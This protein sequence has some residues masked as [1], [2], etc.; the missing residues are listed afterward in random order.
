MAHLSS[1]PTGKVTPKQF[2]HTLHEQ[3]LLSLRQMLRKPLSEHTVRQWLIK[4]GW[5]CTMLRKGMYMDGYE[6]P[7]VVQYQ[8]NTFLPLMAL[9]EKRMVEWIT[10]GFKLVFINPKLGPDE[11]RVIVVSQ[12]KSAFHVNEYKAEAWCTPC[13][14]SPINVLNG[15][16]GLDCTWVSK[17]S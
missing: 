7:D 2:H 4:L 11:K 16:K 8:V 1:L 9:H 10:N 15:L 13:F 12:N 17:S 5:R 14:L 3:I 6:R